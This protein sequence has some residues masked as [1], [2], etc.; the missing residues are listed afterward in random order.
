MKVKDVDVGL[1]NETVNTY[2]PEN[3]AGA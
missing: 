3:D 1:G 2:L